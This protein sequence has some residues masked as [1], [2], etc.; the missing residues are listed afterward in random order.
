MPALI[1]H[2]ARHASRA[3]LPIGQAPTRPPPE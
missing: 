2:A 3:P 1:R